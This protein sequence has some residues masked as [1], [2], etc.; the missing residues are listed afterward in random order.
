MR[1][2]MLALVLALAARLAQAQLPS[3]ERWRPMV[4]A[5]DSG[6]QC[7]QMYAAVREHES[8]ALLRFGRRQDSSRVIAVVWDSVGIIRYT[9]ARGDRR[10]PPSRPAERG[11]RTSILI[12]FRED[13]AILLNEVGTRN[14]GSTMASASAA[15]D[16][17]HLGPPRA[18]LERLHRE[19]GT[20][21]L[22]PNESA[23]EP[24]PAAPRR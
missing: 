19:C 16:A 22:P 1:I 10:G 14:L 11:A 4:A 23:H 5:I 12:Q 13:R 24:P 6:G 8:G 20:P 2:H 17:A 21:A 3:V 15:L 9:D 7:E 18:M